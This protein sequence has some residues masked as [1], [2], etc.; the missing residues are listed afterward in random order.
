MLLAGTAVLAFQRGGSQPDDIWRAAAV[1]C[2][3]LAGLALT[4]PWPIVRGRW[5]VAAVASLA[6]LAGWTALSIN[7]ARVQMSAAD[8]SGR[9]LIYA[10]AFAAAAI[11][12]R[13]PGVRRVTPWALLAGITAASVYGLGTRLLPETFV[14]EIFTPAGAR[15]SH[16]IT[17]WNGMGFLA[18]AGLLLAVACAAQSGMPRAAR[19]A[20]SAAGVLCGFAC[21][22]TLSRGAFASIMCG[23]VVL[24]LMRPRRST[25]VAA[26][27][28]LVPAGALAALTI[29]FT[30]VREAPH[31]GAS[32]Q[33]S[34][35][36]VI[37][38]LVLVA[39]GLAAAAAALLVTR[40]PARD[41]R[42]LAPR[43][44]LR[45]AGA[46]VC[47]SLVVVV[48]TSYLSEQTESLPTSTG[49]LGEAK[50]FRAPYWRV[51]LGSFADHPAI[52][53]GTGSFRVEWRREAKVARATFDAHSIYFET[54]CELGLVGGLL[55]AA[56]IGSLA[57]GTAAAVRAEPDD[58]VLAAAAAVMA[59]FA[60][61]VGVDW[62]WELPAVSLPVLLLAAAAITRP[63]P[64][65]R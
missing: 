25:G 30:A 64:S 21:Y 62:D 9:L 41:Q 55:L 47:V 34:Q 28:V 23:L 49:R 16:P 50:T 5:P 27:C 4:A 39:A 52:G 2:A 3:V 45:L 36:R 20:A 43:R 7:W 53:V 14:A 65:I 10:S 33:I 18:G 13:S 38:A 22:L 37:A 42:L 58:P 54:L 1:A 51:A 17:Y 26:L 6:G 19:A 31:E 57:M 59:A 32:D 46:V 11:V 48:G 60:V 35:G 24:W 61:H 15:L 63:E 56:F 12:M 29:A 8:D 44:A 40:D